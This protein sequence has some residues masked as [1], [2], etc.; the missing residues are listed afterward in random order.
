MTVPV[1]AIVGRPNVGK[2]SLF[3]ALAGRRIA[4]VDPTPGVTRDRVSTLVM[5]DQ[6]YFELVDTGGMGV[7]DVD[8]LTAE[9]EQQ[10]ATAI[11]QAHVI[12][13]VADGRAGITPLDSQVADRLR[14]VTKPIICVVNKCDTPS[15]DPQAAEC[16]Q[17]GFSPL[18][19]VSAQHNR[20]KREL[21]DLI[22]ERLPE[23]EDAS[24]NV[25]VAM[26]LAIVGRRNTGKSTFI[27]SL[28]QTERMIVSEVPG[29][30]R[31]SVDVRFERDGKVFIAIDTAG[32]RRKKSVASDIEF[33]SL[34]RAS[35]RFVAPTWCC[36]SSMRPSGSAK[37]I[38]SSPSTSSNSTSR[39]FS[40]PTNGT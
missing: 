13:F 24:P 10:I 39:R 22:L 2:S 7:Q 17:L 4:I 3:N 35:A 32:V 33:Y 18:L 25:N 15:V 21:L 27:N 16:Y 1:V 8:N 36:S 34:T 29:T 38:N 31:D 23:P 14:P 20:G 30:T 28:A 9:I 40:S 37:W 5:A 11:D 19:C 6:R 12:L 26:K